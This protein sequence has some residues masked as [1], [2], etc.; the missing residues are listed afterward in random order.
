[1]PQVKSLTIGRK[2]RRKA[3]TT[4][5]TVQTKPKKRKIPNLQSNTLVRRIRYAINFGDVH[6]LASSAGSIQNYIY[7]SNDCYDPYYAVGGG[8]P[9]AFTTYMKLYTRFAVL[10][11][12]ASI[13]FTNPSGNALNATNC[14][15]M[16]S[17][18]PTA[19]S[20]KEHI[21]Y[22]PK[23]RVKTMTTRDDRIL[24]RNSYSYKEQG[25][26]DLK[27][28]SEL[29]GSSTTSPS[30]GS[31]FHIGSYTLNGDSSTIYFSGFIDYVVIFMDPVIPGRA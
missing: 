20:I 21:V 27:D 5:L 11:S 12:K 4:T 3:E 19:P 13:L 10:G 7:R 22:T 28:C 31:Y 9:N 30:K 18:N 2:P 6:V 14:Y 24:I 26:K 15:V 16:G 17:P 23:S 1:M 8:Q 25:V 29:F